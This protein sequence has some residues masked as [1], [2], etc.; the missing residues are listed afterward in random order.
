MIN[1]KKVKEL[2][3]KSERIRELINSI[4]EQQNIIEA[5]RNGKIVI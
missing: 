2:G 5:V 4:E 1:H 3:I